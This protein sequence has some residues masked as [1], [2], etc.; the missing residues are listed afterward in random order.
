M[1]TGNEFK[2]IRKELAMTQPKLAE[3]LGI[4]LRT[5]VNLEKAEAVKNHYAFA[6]QYLLYQDKLR[7][8]HR[9]TSNMA[10]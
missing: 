1:M 7:D 3:T 6:V 2:A 9:I 5:V 8:I 10:L 4:T